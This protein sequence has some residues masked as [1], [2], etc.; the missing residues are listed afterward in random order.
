LNDYFQ[1]QITREA[2]VYDFQDKSE[3]TTGVGAPRPVQCT[4]LACT[5]TK[6]AMKKAC[7][8]S[9]HPSQDSNWAPP[10]HKLETLPFPLTIPV[11]LVR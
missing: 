11:S 7:Q 6:T 9:C 8:H 10:K 3:Y 5:Y 1:S 2:A 4:T